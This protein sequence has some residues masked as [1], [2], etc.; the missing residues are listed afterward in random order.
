MRAHPKSNDAELDLFKF[1]LAKLD[2]AHKLVQT[3]PWAMMN[4]TDELTL[5][6]IIKFAYP[7]A[8][9]ILPFPVLTR[10]SERN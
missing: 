1:D 10:W 5:K 8:K 3:V 2:G 7:T 4:A 9:R 6:L